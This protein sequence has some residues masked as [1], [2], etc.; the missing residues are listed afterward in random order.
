MQKKARLERAGIFKLDWI[1]R[2]FEAQND[3]GTAIKRSS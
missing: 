2:L 3:V 1:L